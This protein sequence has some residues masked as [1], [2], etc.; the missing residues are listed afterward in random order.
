ML[1]ISIFLKYYWLKLFK[2]LKFNNRLSDSGFD[3][4][5]DRA[6]RGKTMI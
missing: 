6:R 5:V 4:I 3:L 2:E 1:I